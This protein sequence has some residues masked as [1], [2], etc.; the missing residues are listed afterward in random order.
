MSMIFCQLDS[1]MKSKKKKNT[2]LHTGLKV[3][4]WVREKAVCRLVLVILARW[5][6]LAAEEAE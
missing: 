6:N 1:E 5:G 4:Y 3:D 2:F